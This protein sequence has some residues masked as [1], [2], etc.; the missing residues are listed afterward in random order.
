MNLAHPSPQKQRYLAGIGV[1]LAVHGLLISLWQLS[2]PPR[3]HENRAET[4]ML[5]RLIPAPLRDQSVQR[6]PALPASP[7]TVQGRARPAAANTPATGRPAAGC[8]RARHV[9]G[10][11]ATPASS[12]RTGGAHRAG[13][14]RP[15]QGTRRRG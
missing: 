5:L 13:R 12:A 15:R 4:A 2:K 1:S 3:V 6:T 9:G 11:R 7:S 8:D 10:V 14:Q